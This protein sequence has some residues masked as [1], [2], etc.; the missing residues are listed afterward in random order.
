MPW[1]VLLIVVLI[2]CGKIRVTP[3]APEAISEEIKLPAVLCLCQCAQQCDRQ[4]LVE[5]IKEI[6]NYQQQGMTKDEL[7]FMRASISQGKAL[8]MKPV[9]KGRFIRTIQKYK[10]DHHFTDKQAQIINSIDIPELNKLAQQNL[11]INEMIM[12]VV[13]DQ[14]KIE[15]GLKALGYRSK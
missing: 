5:F 13:G 4:T 6:K 7:A 8:V 15:A 10:L 11:N 12:L 1:V 9:S 2:W 3:M 14:A